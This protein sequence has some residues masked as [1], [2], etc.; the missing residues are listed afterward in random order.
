MNDKKSTSPAGINAERSDRKSSSKKDRVDTWVVLISELLFVILP[1]IIIFMLFAYKGKIWQMLEISEWAFAA[2]VLSG[3]TL[4]KF[5]SGILANYT[6]FREKRVTLYVVI[7]IVFL[8]SPSLSILVLVLIE[9]E[10][11]GP[12]TN[13]LSIWLVYAQLFMFALAVI[14]YLVLGGV[15]ELNKIKKDSG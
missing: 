5:I 10:A 14:A 12:T 15:G 2:A 9:K 6:N 4:A 3:Q 11:S 1:F 13:P 8:I 7:L